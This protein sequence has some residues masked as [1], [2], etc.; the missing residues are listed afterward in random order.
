MNGDSYHGKSHL[1]RIG[2]DLAKKTDTPPL[3]KPFG[4]ERDGARTE[5]PSEG[6]GD[7]ASR[8]RDGEAA[9]ARTGPASGDRSAE[10]LAAAAAVLVELVAVAVRVQRNRQP[11][12]A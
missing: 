8:N 12:G 4:R 5:I 3:S 11:V 7:D 1:S 2:L 9:P 6:S 10:R